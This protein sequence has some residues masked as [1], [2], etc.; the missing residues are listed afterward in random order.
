[1]SKLFLVVV[2][3]TI[4]FTAKSQTKA[5]TENGREVI[6]FDNGTW[7]YTDSSNESEP[8]SD[9]LTTNPHSY[10][11]PVNAS[12]LVKSNVCNVGVFID[13]AKWTF[14]PHKDNEVGIEYRFELKSAEGYAMILTEKTPIDLENMRQIALLNAQKAAYDAKIIKAEYRM[15]NKLKVLCMEMRGTIKGIKFVY[16]GYYYSNASGTTQLISF[17][18]QE[19][20]EKSKDDLEKLLNG[21][22]EREK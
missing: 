15:V 4:F 14:S 6:L 16:F 9:S 13:P 21:L 17:S 12:F 1:M 5:L 7:K 3:T 8:I 20:F 2:L 11:K 10:S 19:L 18:S 22:V